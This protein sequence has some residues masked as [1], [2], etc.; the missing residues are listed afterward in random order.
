M[1]TLVSGD[2]GLESKESNKEAN[3]FEKEKKNNWRYRKRNYKHIS[4]TPNKG[5]Q[6]LSLKHTHKLKQK[7]KKKI[8]LLHTD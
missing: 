8:Y 6:R 3:P 5:K 2:Y 7:V 4:K 1:E